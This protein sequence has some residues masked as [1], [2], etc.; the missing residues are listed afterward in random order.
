M[1]VSER[2]THITIS[3][4]ITI[5]ARP[6]GDMVRL[7]GGEE[8]TFDHWLRLAEC[9]VRSV[10]AAIGR[11]FASITPSE[12]QA[13]CE[14]RRWLRACGIHD[15]QGFLDLEA[16][17]PLLRLPPD[18]TRARRCRRCGSRIWGREALLTGYGSSCRRAR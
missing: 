5:K 4:N 17:L 18:P 16:H 9:A 6:N 12:Y 13:A 8:M 2:S 3:M 1:H 11:P 7:C 15:L 14:G 10:R